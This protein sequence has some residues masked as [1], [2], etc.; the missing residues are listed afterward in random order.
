MMIVTMTRHGARRKSAGRLILLRA[1]VAI[2]CA[3]SVLAVIP[4]VRAGVDPRSETYW[5]DWQTGIA[6][7]GYDPLS[8]FIS[9]RPQL[10][11]S[12]H[13]Y[14]WLGV[15]WRFMNAGN[16]AAFAEAPRVY[17]P[18]FGGYDPVALSRDGLVEGNPLIWTIVDGRLLLFQSQP[19]RAIW[20][21]EPERYTR[22]AAAGWPRQWHKL[23]RWPQ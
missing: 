2:L 23:P 10:G 21:S 19:Y 11:S 12:A 15:T 8:Y 3:T 22:E 6:I 13:E 4:G 20:E 5:F 9:G 7:G 14:V 1:I 16:L 17:A 18:L